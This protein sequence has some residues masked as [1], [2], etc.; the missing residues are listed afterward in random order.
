MTVRICVVLALSSIVLSSCAGPQPT[1]LQGAGSMTSPAQLSPPAY[2]TA[3]RQPETTAPSAPKITGMV[4]ACVA[5]DYDRKTRDGSALST[6]GTVSL[7]EKGIIEGDKGKSGWITMNTIG[8]YIDDSTKARREVTLSGVS[9]WVNGG[10][11]NWWDFEVQSIHPADN[12]S[13]PL[14]FETKIEDVKAGQNRP[15]VLLEGKYKL[16]PSGGLNTLSFEQ[17]K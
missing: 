4:L 14:K 1:G 11:D 15:V 13:Q 7:N 12:P 17:E 10:G 6:L 3:A 8:S 9:F 2:S 16:V 5:L